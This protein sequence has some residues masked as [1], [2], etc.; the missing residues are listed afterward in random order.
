MRLRGAIPIVAVLLLAFLATIW[1]R[2]VERGGEPASGHFSRETA[3]QKAARMKWWVDARFG[4]FIHWGPVSLK[5]TEIG[6]SRGKE[7]PVNVYD[8]LY[9]EFNPTKFNAEE[10][11]R[12]AKAAGMKYIV[13]TAKHH[14]GFS[15]FATRYS[16][17]NIMNTPFKRDITKELAEE[18]RRQGIVFCTYY[19]IIDWHHPDYLPRG[20]GGAVGGRPAEAADYEL[21]FAF[22]KNQ[23]RELVENYGPLGVLWFDGD[24]DPTWTH[25]R[26]MEVSNLV[27]SIQPSIILNNRV[28]KGRQGMDGFNDPAT[29]NVGDFETPEQKAGKFLAD[30]HRY[31]ESCVTIGTQWAWKPNDQLKSSREIIQLLVRNAGMD[32]NFLL[33]VGPMPTGEIEPRQ[34][35]L[36]REVGRWMGAYGESIY[37]TRGGP[38]QP[39][40]WG[41]TTHKDDTIYL[42]VLNWQQGSVLRLPGIGKKIISSRM[43]TGGSARVTQKADAIAINLPPQGRR[44]IDTVIALKLDGSAGEI[45]FMAA[46]IPPAR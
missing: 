34:A 12:L 45:P 41:V 2:A 30:P 46:E 19:S 17:Y 31:W 36:L 4:M 5:G 3:T 8:N 35:S 20:P 32:G 44:E 14:D 22:M 21:Y 10:Y 43:L 37:G 6:W 13:L 33:N 16:D 25:A 40:Q 27:R 28:D 23:L 29:P 15:M 39:A 38:F 24:W 7:V 9:K 18:C 11:V 42:H 26:A 1:T